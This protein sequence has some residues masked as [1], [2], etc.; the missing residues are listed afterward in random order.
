M[1]WIKRGRLRVSIHELHT[2]RIPN[3]I[4]IMSTTISLGISVNGSCT[5]KG[6]DSKCYFI[7]FQR[8]FEQPNIATLQELET[9]LWVLFW[10]KN[11][12]RKHTQKNKQNGAD[13][14]VAEKCEIPL[15]RESTW[16][17]QGRD[18]RTAVE[19]VFDDS[20]VGRRNELVVLW[21]IIL[22]LPLLLH[23]C[24]AHRRHNGGECFLFYCIRR[25]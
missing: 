13:A 8:V 25:T 6:K 22:F 20:K 23:V 18:A 14:Q 17:R 15:H 3:M 10:N 5:V 21:K 19:S 7:S 16:I 2:Q 11:A 1:Q 24:C 12:R 9:V 4:F